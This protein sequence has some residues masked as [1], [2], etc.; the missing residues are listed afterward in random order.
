[1]ISLERPGGRPLRIGH[2]GAPAL[3]PENTLP[4]FRAAVDVGVDLVEFD[5]AEGPGG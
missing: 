2:R 3:A 5:V 4:S 1:M